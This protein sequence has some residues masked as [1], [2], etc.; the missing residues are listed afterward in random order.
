MFLKIV[1]NTVSQE[2]ERTGHIA[3]LGPG[4]QTALLGAKRCCY[5]GHLS[6]YKP[7]PGHQTALLGAQRCCYT[8]HSVSQPH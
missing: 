4:H 8:G 5:T 7:G 6:H 2:I 3:S 1:R